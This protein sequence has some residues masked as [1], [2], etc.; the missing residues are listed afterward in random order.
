MACN[1]HLYAPTAERQKKV[2]DFGFKKY[3]N[4]GTFSQIIK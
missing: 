3:N 1:R 4:E 2:L